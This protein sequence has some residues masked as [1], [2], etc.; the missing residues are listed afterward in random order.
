MKFYVTTVNGWESLAVVTKKS[1][2]VLAGVLDLLLLEI[3]MSKLNQ[4][5]TRG[6]EFY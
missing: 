4:H 1:I 2:L 5:H 6:T 3:E